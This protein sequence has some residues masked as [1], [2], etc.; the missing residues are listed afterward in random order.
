MFTSRLKTSN[1]KARASV[2]DTIRVKRK[3]LTATFQQEASKSL[4]CSLIQEKSVQKAE[5]IAIYLAVNG[6]LDLQPFIK[7]CWQQNKQTYVPVVHP[8]SA[9]NLL[10][11]HYHNNSKMVLNQYKIK[12]PALDVRD[13]KPVNTLDIIL[14]PLVAFDSSGARIGMG[15][16]Y[17]DRT[18]AQWYK[19]YTK[20]IRFNPIPIGIAHDC[21]HVENVP[22]ETWD[23]PL[24]KII[25]PSHTF[26]FSL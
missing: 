20:Q 8:F 2:R 15:G 16:G 10:F 19:Q 1:E 14:T 9:G 6:E 12:E 17:Y 3:M 22:V 24:P 25:T 7:W 13:I 4:L 21:Q 18:L 5:H 23:I 11:L 26:N